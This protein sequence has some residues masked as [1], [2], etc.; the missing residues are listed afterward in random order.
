MKNFF[1]G[2]PQEPILSAL[3]FNIIS[4]DLFYL[5]EGVPV[6]SYADDTTLYCA[7]KTNDLAIKET[8]HFY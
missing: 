7:N 5:L 6:A 4:C 1:C 3:I 8:E 2:I